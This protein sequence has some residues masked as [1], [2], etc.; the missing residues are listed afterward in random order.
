M[1]SFLFYD[2]ETSGLHCAF[3]QILTFAAIRTDLSLNELD[4]LS[5]MV[6][7]R[8]DVVPSPSAFI[9]HRLSPAVLSEQGCHEYEAA[10]RIH[11]LVNTPGTISLGYN[12]LGF[13]DEFLRFTFYRNLLDPYTHQFANGC[14]RMDILPLALLYR[15]FNP[16]DIHWPSSRDGR[17]TMKL[18]EISRDNQLVSSGRAHDA[19]VDVEATLALARRLFADR[20]M[21]EYC[22]GFFDKSTE[23]ER[24]FRMGHCTIGHAGRFRMGIMVSLSFGAE[25]LYMGPVLGI[26][27]SRVYGNQTLWL[28]LD[29]V[30]FSRCVAGEEGAEA[31]F[32]LRKK[33]GEAPLVLPALER[34]W[35]RLALSRRKLA[36]K[37]ID[38]LSR[39]VSWFE[40]QVEQHRNY[41]Y[42]PV[43]DV[44]L[45][46]ALYQDG[47]FSSLEKKEMG[48][49]HQAPPDKK[50]VVVS[51]LQM[52]RIRALAQRVL[53]RN[54]THDKD[55]PGQ[56]SSP[57]AMAGFDAAAYMRQVRGE[58][59]A[60]PLKGYKNDVRYDVPMAR[61]E[62]GALLAEEQT[63]KQGLDQEQKALLHAV[64][65]HIDTI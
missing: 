65:H 13:D 1:K 38:V 8:P 31:L 4:R 44:D 22:L 3:D 24:L 9:T 52:H 36:L 34:F 41:A 46:A 54:F 29:N 56:F 57:G 33:K 39:H 21:W 5:V 10:C 49:F 59:D 2:I 50:A 55:L 15:I 26:G 48:V 43:P 20:K 11:G 62:L 64:S 61:K 35:N 18:E 16:L 6:R 25:A 7:L 32:V 51:T 12:T 17:P 53:F 37:N 45:D 58:E 63:L 47:F 23:K 19:M 14:G 40:Q 60:H 30:D 27:D 42:P 28:R